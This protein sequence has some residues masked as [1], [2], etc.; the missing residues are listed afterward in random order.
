MPQYRLTKKF[1]DDCHISVLSSPW[2][3][4]SVVDDWFIDNFSIGDEKITMATHAKTL[5]TLLIPYRATGSA[6]KTIEQLPQLFGDFLTRCGYSTFES[7]QALQH[8]SDQPS[9]FCKTNDHSVLGVMSDFK[10]LIKHLVR[11]TS[12]EK[13]DWNRLAIFL[14]DV[15]VKVRGADFSTPRELLDGFLSRPMLVH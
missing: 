6:V 12:F 10:R 1:S 14:S 11:D 7:T 15:P 8:L 9:Q 4:D 5:C 13:I 3:I 2:R